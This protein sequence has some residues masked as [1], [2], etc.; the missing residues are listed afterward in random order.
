MPEKIQ[1]AT[2]VSYLTSGF[3]IG[4]GK[5]GHWITALDWNQIAIVSGVVIG[6]VTF[7]ANIHFQRQRNKY[8]ERQTKAIEEAALNGGTVIQPEIE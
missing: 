6:V 8:L 7:L 5:L 3:L 1:L 4:L 2:G